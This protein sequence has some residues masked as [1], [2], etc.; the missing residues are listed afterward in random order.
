[1]CLLFSYLKQ[2]L[3]RPHHGQNVELGAK[4]KEKKVLVRLWTVRIK[5]FDVTTSSYFN[6]FLVRPHNGKKVELGVKK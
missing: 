4:K 5:L 1:M 2:F 3:V 6:Q